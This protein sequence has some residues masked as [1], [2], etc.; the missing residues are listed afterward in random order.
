[1]NNFSRERFKTGEEYSR[2]LFFLSPFIFLFSISFFQ[3]LNLT[4]FQGD[5]Y[6]TIAESNRI[7]QKPINPVRGFIYDRKGTLL[8]ENIVQRDL[9]VTPAYIEDSSKTILTLS[10]L[11]DMPYELLEENFSR[12]AKKVKKFD[13]FPLVK[14]LN[15]EQIAKAKVN[16]DSISGIEVKA[17]LKRYVLHE[18]TSAHI[19]GYVGDVSSDEIRR[20]KLLAELQNIQIGKIGIEKEFDFSLRGK[21]G[22][23]TQERDVK[24]KLVRVLDTQGAEDGKDI[25]LTIDQELQDHLFKLFKNRRGALVA[26]EPKTGF[27]RALISSPSYNPNILNSIV[28]ANEVKGLFS[29]KE[30]PIFNRAIS[31]QYPPAS[32]LKPFIGLAAIE[33]GVISWDKKIKDDGKFY[34]EGD[35]RPYRG[36]KES[37]HGRVDMRKAIAES[38]DVYFYNLAYDLTLSGIRPMLDS[39]G[40]GKKTGL[41]DSEAEGLL[42]DKKWKLGYKGDFWFKGDTI[43]LGIGQ[44]YIL[45]TPIQLAMA[46]SGLANRGVI[47][48]PQLLKPEDGT[49]FKPKKI[50]EIQLSGNETWKK[51]EQALVDVI[52]AKNGTAHKVFDAKSA[53][54][55]GKTG[56]AQ[57]KSILPGKEYDAIRENPALR[58]HA[59]FVGYGPVEDPEL[60]VAVIIENGESGSEVAA[61]I[62]KSA[63][64]FYTGRLNAE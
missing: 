53:L 47:Y 26:L 43:N 24:G 12:G 60:V 17:T 3:V 40:F 48:Q 41:I 1:M 2:A 4:L 11:L 64:N 19:I 62:V 54:I 33:N 61:P 50:A 25:Y 30:S 34:V 37:G 44:G 29:N 9:Y 39:F 51:M 27:V 6:Q 22:V 59:L 28:D 46:Y 20:D 32:T 56:T 14:A 36:W 55:A 10:N 49:S 13:S 5:K 15:E 31:G 23:Q 63:I 18:E 35:P 57:I 7:Y 42:P 45:A 58:D 52:S 16:L 8:A 38:S 21:P